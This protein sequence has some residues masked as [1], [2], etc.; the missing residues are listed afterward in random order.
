M[1]SC[2]FIGLSIRASVFSEVSHDDRNLETEKSHVSK[3]GEKVPKMKLC[4]FIIFVLLFVG[5]NLKLKSLHFPVCL[6]KFHIWENSVSQIIGQ[7]CSHSTRLQDCLIINI[8][9]RN[10][11]I[12]LIFLHGDIHQRKVA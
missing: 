5:S 11:P 3:N 4:F 1:N 6:W 10:A 8:Y 12:S 9:G 2:L 7:N